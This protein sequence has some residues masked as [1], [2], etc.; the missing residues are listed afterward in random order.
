M[1]HEFFS[2]NFGISRACTCVHSRSSVPYNCFCRKQLISYGIFYYTLLAFSI[3]FVFFHEFVIRFNNVLSNMVLL[4]KTME[5]T[6]TTNR[7]LEVYIYTS[8][9]GRHI[10]VTYEIRVFFEGAQKEVFSSI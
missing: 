8:H 10:V 7:V 9:I 4:L 1:I 5:A 3:F 2:F 6:K